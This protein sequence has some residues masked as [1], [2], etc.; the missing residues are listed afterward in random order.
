M[1][2]ILNIINIIHK[3]ATNIV[4]AMSNDLV[5]PGKYMIEASFGNE[6]HKLIPGWGKELHESG[7]IMYSNKLLHIYSN[8]V[9]Y[10]YCE[11]LIERTAYNITIKY[12]PKGMYFDS[13]Y[14]Y[15]D[16]AEFMVNK[17]QYIMKYDIDQYKLL[18]GKENLTKEEAIE[19]MKNIDEYLRPFEKIIK[20]NTFLKN[21]KT[22]LA[23]K[24]HKIISND[25]LN[26]KIGI[27]FQRYK[28]VAEQIVKEN[29]KLNN[30]EILKEH[31]YKIDKL[32]DDL[33]TMI[34]YY[35][36]L[37]APIM[38]NIFEKVVND[39][40]LNI[41]D[42][43]LQVNTQPYFLI[44]PKYK[45]IVSN[46]DLLITPIDNVDMNDLD[47]FLKKYAEYNKK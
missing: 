13:G 5:D 15:K 30:N 22:L 19:I 25:E 21:N 7:H 6:Y 40:P 3:R 18:V 41:D 36:F 31:I 4:N 11:Q 20:I 28:I 2:D 37:N 9:L 34:Y 33:Q 14:N 45:Y 47:N 16:N 29:S 27:A 8:G 42:E 35:V 23:D 46:I 39:M 38:E 32:A 10:W 12:F 1:N 43:F 44:W 26:K 17:Q 24:L